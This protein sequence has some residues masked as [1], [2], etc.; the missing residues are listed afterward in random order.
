MR[1]KKGGALMFTMIAPLML[2]YPPAAVVMEGVVAVSIPFGTWLVAAFTVHM[3]VLVGFEL[4][5]LGRPK[6]P[7]HRP[8]SLIRGHHPL[9]G[10]P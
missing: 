9:Q 6:L 3:L 7:G 4:M 10:R 5:R 8:V 1:Q 2:W